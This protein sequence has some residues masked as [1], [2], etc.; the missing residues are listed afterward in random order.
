MSSAGR[1]D[2]GGGVF[3]THVAVYVAVLGLRGR[4]VPGLDLPD[5]VVPVA[6]HFETDDPTDDLKVTLSD[7][8]LAYVSAKR[9]VGNDGQLRSTV[10]DWVAQLDDAQPNDLF[11][12]AAEELRGDVRKL[13]G[14]LR[15]HRE[16]VPQAERPTD[17]A[18]IAAITKSVPER[19]HAEVLRRARLLHLPN[20]TDGALGQAHLA[21]L[22]ANI[23]QDGNGAGVIASLGNEFARQAGV[24]DA[25]TI[26]DWESALA[27]DGLVVLPDAGGYPAQRAAARRRAIDAYRTHLTQRQGTIDLS[28]LADDLPPVHVDGLLSQIQVRRSRED[29][30]SRSELIVCVRRWRR[31]LV[32]GSPGAGKSVAVRELAAHCADHPHAPIPV[33]V[34]LVKALA[35]REQGLDLDALLDVCVQE[36]VGEEH[37]LALRAHLHQAVANGDAIVI[38]DGLDECGS[39]AASVAQQLH[40]ITRQ[41]PPRLGLV[42]TTRPSAERAAARL[43]LP[44]GELVEPTGLESTIDSILKVCADQ[45]AAP[46]QRDAWL[47]SRQQWLADARKAHGELMAIP[48]LATLVTLI[49]ADTPE[50]D[51]PSGRARVLHQA[52]TRSVKR[53]ERQR[54]TP[55]DAR[56]WAPEVSP[57]MLLD[58][59]TDLG[60]MLD[61]KSAP[62]KQDALHTLE[63][64][65]RG[66]R[67]A[68]P[69]ARAEE[70]A[71]DVL[72]FWDERVAVFVV[73]ASDEI[74]SR[75]RVFVDIALAMWAQRGPDDLHKWLAEVIAYTDTDDAI[76]LAAELHPPVIDALLDLGATG[77]AAA[78]A[79]VLVL[80]ADRGISLDDEQMR[81]LL[82]NVKHHV[83][84]QT[85][86]VRRGRRNPRGALELIRARS[87][88]LVSIAD[89]VL[90]V[91]KLTLTAA[92]REERDALIVAADLSQDE[93]AILVAVAGLADAASDRSSLDARVLD[94]IEHVMRMPVPTSDPPVQRTSRRRAH[95]VV[96]PPRPDGVAQVALG[97]TEHLG[98]IAARFPDAT[99]WIFDAARDART[100]IG[101][102]IHSRLRAADAR[103]A[104][105]R[106]PDWTDAL[107]GLGPTDRD[108]LTLL[109]DFISLAPAGSVNEPPDLWSLTAAGDLL[110]AMG[111]PT[112]SYGDFHHG[113]RSEFHALRRQWIDIVARARGIDRATVAAQ[114][115]HIRQSFEGSNPTRRWFSEDW[116]V[117]ATQSASPVDP[118][119]EHAE[120]LSVRDQQTLVECLV[121]GSDWLAHSAAELLLNANETHWDPVEM[122]HR[123]L[124]HL[125]MYDAALA[126]AVAVIAERE[127][128]TLITEAASSPESCLRLAGRIAI[129]IAEEL[130]DTERIMT[131]LSLDDDL[132]VRPRKSRMAEPRANYWTCTRC[133]TRNAIDEE[134]CAGCDYGNR[135]KA[136]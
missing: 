26:D 22:A 33:V 109:E 83:A 115:E 14:A 69:G 57:M 111:F 30:S 136:E 132:T 46:D 49:C 59:F 114:A 2:A 44:R 53:W 16:A 100:G 88:A 84:S 32:V 94:A 74:A 71:E 103:A 73:G 91:C 105:W 99:R 17:L 90:Q 19:L 124:S 93:R 81:R 67:W 7:G 18:A 133:W 110:E 113:F 127:T 65:L 6:L 40:E 24:G 45:R 122:F 123:D 12:L 41:L 66:P 97:V 10:E 126:Y 37:R 51:L 21:E 112:V 62:T 64:T 134:E 96:T 55:D 31:L 56:S 15:R 36:S 120:E 42:V 38:C 118:D 52:L 87:A 72:R 85:A 86:P 135:P 61:E 106:L 68:L 80:I 63:R 11:V 60:R 50:A 43:D 102:R 1:A 54:T 28:L 130:D 48:L 25:S 101:E 95:F 107:A 35:S 5:Y 98:Q 13:E 117:I 47:A 89:L 77:V 29:R 39:R 34:P 131:A 116:L 27:R 129:E 20:A 92:M 58:G 8:R 125:G 4:T 76:G 108:D 119:R 79:M 70:V 128:G 121:S 3:R 23:V 78:T 75:S 9:A 82:T 104:E